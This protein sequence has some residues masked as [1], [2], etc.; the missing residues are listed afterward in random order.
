MSD[1]KNTRPSRMSQV[2]RRAR[3]ERRMIAAAL[4]IIAERGV[5]GMTLTEVGERAGYSRALPAHQFGSRSALLCACVRRVIVEHWVGSLPAADDLDGLDAIK[6]A[7][8]RWLRELQ[9]RSTVSRAYFMLLQNAL[10]LDAEAREPDLTALVRSL[11]RGGESR[12]RDYL[13][14][15]QSDGRLSPLVDPDHEA[16]MIHTTLTGISLRWLVNPAS[17]NPDLFGQRY[18][19]ELG[20]RLERNAP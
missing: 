12:Y 3:S 4:E 15:A 5:N 18:L 13:L 7:V 17:V 2:E 1:I 9:E 14:R 10:S 11:A 6:A 8:R 20:Q 16:L 19:A